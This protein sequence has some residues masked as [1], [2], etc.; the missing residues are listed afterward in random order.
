M[1]TGILADL[2]SALAKKQSFSHNFSVSSSTQVRNQKY[3]TFT[4]VSGLPEI[5]QGLGGWECIYLSMILLWNHS[6]CLPVR[7]RGKSSAHRQWLCNAVMQVLLFSIYFHVS[8]CY[9]ENSIISLD[10]TFISYQLLVKKLIF[11][12]SIQQV[13]WRERRIHVL[14]TTMKNFFVVLYIWLSEI[15]NTQ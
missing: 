14:W 15:M 2:F 3:K 7:D 11:S 13:Y 8:F 12:F 4:N 10:W 1:L 5:S 9:L 6:P